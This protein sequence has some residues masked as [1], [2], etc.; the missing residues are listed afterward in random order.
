MPDLYDNLIGKQQTLNSTPGQFLNAIMPDA[1]DLQFVGKLF[2]QDMK[3]MN[4]YLKSQ[5]AEPLLQEY[6]ETNETKLN[7]DI[8]LQNLVEVVMAQALRIS[9]LEKIINKG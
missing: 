9:S 2:E 4:D 6:C 7:T 5:G 3:K 1:E 8:I